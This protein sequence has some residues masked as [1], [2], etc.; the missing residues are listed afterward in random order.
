MKKFFALSALLVVGM[1]TIYFSS[2][3][4]ATKEPENNKVEKYPK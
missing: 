4:N 2:R 3:N 1:A